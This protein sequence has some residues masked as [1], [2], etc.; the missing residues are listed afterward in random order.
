MARRPRILLSTLALA[1]S[2][3]ASVLFAASP[4][5]AVVYCKTVGVPQGCVAR[6]TRVVYCTRPGYPAGCVAKG[7]GAGV[8]AYPG[9]GAGAA[10]VGLAPGAGVGAPGVGAP[11]YGGVNG[12]GP[13]NR[14]GWR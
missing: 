1:G 10:G 14:A 6:P 2:A 9:A 12:G 8:G 5:Q 11:G 3:F 7:N 4:S 13:V